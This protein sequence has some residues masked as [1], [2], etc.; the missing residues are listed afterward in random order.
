MAGTAEVGQ[1][2]VTKWAIEIR[3]DKLGLSF[4]RL[5]YVDVIH[6]LSSEYNI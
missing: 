5:N 1:A 4:G 2:E 6:L 3:S